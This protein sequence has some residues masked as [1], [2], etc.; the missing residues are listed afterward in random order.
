MAGCANRVKIDELRAKVTLAILGVQRIDLDLIGAHPP[1][2]DVFLMR[3]LHVPFLQT[4]I[5]G[6]VSLDNLVQRDR[7]LLPSLLGILPQ[8]LNGRENDHGVFGSG[9]NIDHLAR[10]GFL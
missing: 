7:K 10:C 3:E 5:R 6:V 9:V 8:F 4:N 1:I 2:H